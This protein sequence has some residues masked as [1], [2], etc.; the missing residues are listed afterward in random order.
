VAGESSQEAR[1]EIRDK[2]FDGVG[3]RPQEAQEESRVISDNDAEAASEYLRDKSKL[4]GQLRGR[5]EYASDNLRRVKALEMM[6]L[7]GGL[8]ERETRAYAS[9]AYRIALEERRE[10]VTEYETE[11]ALRDAAQYRIDIWR[12]QTAS[13]RQG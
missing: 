11:R 10:A 3:L 8:G 9:E 12:S 1:A 7:D 2:R 4:Y 13:R 6:A 5:M